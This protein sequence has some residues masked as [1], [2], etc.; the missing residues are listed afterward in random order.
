MIKKTVLLAVSTAISAGMAFADWTKVDDMDYADQA[1][2]D[3]VWSP[4]PLD[5]DGDG[6]GA[7]VAELEGNKVLQMNM[8]AFSETS[9]YNARAIRSIPEIAG[10]G[11]IYVR[12]MVPTVDVG[13][14]PL[15][16]LVDA[17]FGAG[18]R[19]PI[20]DP[21]NP[22]E[23]TEV[24]GSY[25]DFS[26]LGGPRFKTDFPEINFYDFGHPDDTYATIPALEG[27]PT[28]DEW[29]EV[30]FV[31]DHAN[32]GYKVYMRGGPE[33]PEQTL[34]FPLDDPDTHPPIGWGAERAPSLTEPIRTFLI[35]SSAGDLENPKGLDYLYFDD[36]YVDTSAE[37]LSSP[38]AP[39][40]TTT[41]IRGKT[42]RRGWANPISAKS[43]AM[44]RFSCNCRSGPVR[45]SRALSTL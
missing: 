40:K 8:G 16:A 39:A 28:A 1:A 21:E 36:I 10:A 9:G 22:D 35:Y 29:Y 13:G 12:M 42:I 41:A 14:T 6:G 27:A 38:I 20:A 26:L 34:V 33:L 25:N 5:P 30:W 2:M 4:H 7:V 37:N 24:V 19:F 32:N 18:Y 3:A 45:N 23:A 15:T 11:T 17:V 44:T 43:W 31:L